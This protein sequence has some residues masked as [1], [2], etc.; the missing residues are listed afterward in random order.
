MYFEDIDGPAR[1]LK[2][3][4]LR[5]ND[6]LITSGLD[7]IFPPGLHVGRVI[8]IKPLKPG[9]YSYDLEATPSAGDLADLTFVYVLPPVSD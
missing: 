3:G 8:N 7:G 4:I 2:A 9:G 6:L 1:D 5:E